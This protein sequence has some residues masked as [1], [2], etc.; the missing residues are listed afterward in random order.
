MQK[1]N[2]GNCPALFILKHVTRSSKYIYIA[3]ILKKLYKYMYFKDRHTDICTSIKI[4][5][6]SC[7]SFLLIISKVDNAQIAR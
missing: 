1:Q 3:Y 2:R 4:L 5:Y 6:M 7:E